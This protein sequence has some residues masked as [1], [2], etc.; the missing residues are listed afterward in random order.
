VTPG[1]VA[2]AAA[3]A[4]VAAPGVGGAAAGGGGPGTAAPTVSAQNAKAILDALERQGVTRDTLRRRFG[5]SPAASD[6]LLMQTIL[7]SQTM[8]GPTGGTGD[9]T[10]TAIKD[11]LAAINPTI[12]GLQ[13]QIQKLDNDLFEKWKELRAKQQEKT[14]IWLSRDSLPPD[15]SVIVTIEGGLDAYWKKADAA[16]QNLVDQYDDI[17]RRLRAAKYQLELAMQRDRTP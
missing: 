8:E 16:I 3:G 10:K 6:S 14:N 15:L 12:A 1:T 17:D 2:A 9:P 13:A 11:A 4:A 5:L 7:R